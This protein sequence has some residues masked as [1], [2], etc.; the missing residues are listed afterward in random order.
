MK[1]QKAPNDIETILKELKSL[2]KESLPIFSSMVDDIIIWNCKDENHIEL[3]LDRLLDFCFDDENLLLYKKLCRYYLT[4][5][6]I[7]TEDYVKFYFEIYG[8]E[9]WV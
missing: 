6:P 9:K 7:A 2:A 5:N 1:N 8:E 4:I 3:T